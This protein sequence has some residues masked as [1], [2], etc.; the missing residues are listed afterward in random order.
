MCVQFI[1]FSCISFAF[2]LQSEM[3]RQSTIVLG[4]GAL[5]LAGLIL[6]LAV[7]RKKK[8]GTKKPVKPE[9]N[10]P[11]LEFTVTNESVPFIV[12]KNEETLRG[13]E[14]ATG[15][16]IEFKEQDIK[17]Q[18]CLIRGSDVESI[19][20][21]QAM[22][23]E[24]AE[25]PPK[26]TETMTVPSTAANRIIGLCGEALEELC[27][28]T[29]AKVWVERSNDDNGMDIV[30]IEGTQAEINA[31]RLRIEQKVSIF[32]LVEL[33]NVITSARITFFR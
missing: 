7:V 3:S 8:S 10:E 24:H 30:K 12:G 5:S 28:T 9:V 29:K 16:R 21:A 2:N 17:H 20:R 25:H 27:N 33:K 22:V 13:I 15:T 19:Q 6:Y 14:Q 1:N 4:L 31:A 23:K 11:V 32:N 18:L 26:S